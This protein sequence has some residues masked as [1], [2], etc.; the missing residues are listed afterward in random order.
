MV[1]KHAYAIRLWLNAKSD[2][3]RPCF[4]SCLVY[5]RI[6]RIQNRDIIR[7]EMMHDR[8]LDRSVLRKIDVCIEVVRRYIRN[9]RDIRSDLAFVHGF[10]LPTRQFK[11]DGPLWRQLIERGDGGN[12][13]IAGHDGFR[14]PG[15]EHVAAK[16][17]AARLAFGASDTDYRRWRFG[18]KNGHFH[19]DWNA[20]GARRGEQ[21]IPAAD[22]RIAHN[23]IGIDKIALVVPF[24]H[25]TNVQ[26]GESGDLI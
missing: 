17:A 18:E 20:G 6:V 10:Q 8:T 14:I 15:A 22:R 7:P 13:H 9:D 4:P 21:W 3:A 11:N 16:H 2:H 1:W 12:A 19:L 25:V 24:E 23:H 5:F 26:I